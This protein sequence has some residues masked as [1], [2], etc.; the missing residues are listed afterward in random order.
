MR[1]C[2]PG[3]T[4]S[5]STSSVRTTAGCSGACCGAGSCACTTGALPG[6][7]GGGVGV[8][9]VAIVGVGCAGEDK[10]L[11]PAKT[12]TP[13]STPTATTA[14]AHSAHDVRLPPL[15]P[16]GESVPVIEIEISL[17]G[18]VTLGVPSSGWM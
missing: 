17:A 7:E 4:E 3:G 18:G 8:G 5:S 6:C 13:A 12:P 9:R 2:A 1:T 10:S 14:I 16:V 11:V 15:V